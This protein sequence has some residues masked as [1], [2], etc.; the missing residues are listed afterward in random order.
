MQD[1][2]MSSDSQIYQIYDK[3]FIEKMLRKSK[4]SYNN[5]QYSWFLWK[6]TIFLLWCQ[7]FRL[8]N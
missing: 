2:L 5:S 1:V 4:Q 7:H 8:S 6:A 3:K